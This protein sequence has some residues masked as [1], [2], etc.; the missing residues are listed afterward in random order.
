MKI[1]IL[2]ASLFQL[3]NYCFSKYIMNEKNEMIQV[4][5]VKLTSSFQKVPL[6]FLLDA[7]SIKLASF[8]GQNPPIRP[9]R[10]HSPQIR[11]KRKEQRLASLFLRWRMERNLQPQRNFHNHQPVQEN[12]YQ[13]N[14][15]SFGCFAVP[16]RQRLGNH[17]AN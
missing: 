6:T 7:K 4:F 3:I 5:D 12:F 15:N 1:V 8:H 16:I 2:I 10:P 14:R 11:Q 9:I 17:L 13:Q